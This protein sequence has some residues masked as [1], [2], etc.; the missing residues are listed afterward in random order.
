MLARYALIRIA[1]TKHG[2]AEVGTFGWKEDLL[3]RCTALATLWTFPRLKAMDIPTVYMG[4]VVETSEKAR[5]LAQALFDT[6]KVDWAEV[7]LATG[8]PPQS[9]GLPCSGAL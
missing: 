8:D 5:T 6:I 4:R 2:F 7:V 9:R 3:L 1:Y